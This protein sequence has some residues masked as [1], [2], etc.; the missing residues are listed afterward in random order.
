MTQ[1]PPVP[2]S[3]ARAQSVFVAATHGLE[4]ESFGDGLEAEG[5]L[6][7]LGAVPVDAGVPD[8]CSEVLSSSAEDPQATDVRRIED[9]MIE[10][11]SFMT[12]SNRCAPR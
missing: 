7:S 3:Q 8:P 2:Q 9:R 6:G 12:R 1:P 11:G 4:D 10:E 5:G